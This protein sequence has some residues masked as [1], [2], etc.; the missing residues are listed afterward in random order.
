MRT[1]TSHAP[2]YSILLSALAAGFVGIASACAPIPSTERTTTIVTPSRAEFIGSANGS[3]STFL[4]VRCGSLD[5]HG[6]IG[7]PLRIYSADGL[8]LP[9]D[10]GALSP[11]SGATT[12]AE[13]N[14]NFDSVVGVQ[15]EQMSR[16]AAAQG[17]EPETLFIVSKPMGDVDPTSLP[18]GQTTQG[19]EHKGGR[20]ISRGDLGY[21]CITSW[22]GSMQISTTQFSDCKQASTL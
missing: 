16:V 6:S 10:G 18:Q 7:R 5:C 13:Q 12:P 14:A 22:L 8:R 20:V 15:P 1:R 3:V 4:E 21:Q 2:A 17:A 19:V 9:E 11:G